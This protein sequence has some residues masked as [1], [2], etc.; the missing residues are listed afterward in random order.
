MAISVGNGRGGAKSEINVTP[1]VDVVLVLLII[2]MVVTPQLQPGKD[3][4]LPQASGAREGAPPPPALVVSITQAGEVFVDAAS[5]PA[6]A[7]LPQQLTQALREQPGRRLVLRGDRSLTYGEVRRVMQESRAAGAR[8][9]A[10]AV[11]PGKAE[12]A[13]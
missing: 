9:V 4:K 12:G 8:G 13:R 7:A 6:G 10:L 11:E 3:V 2:F 5:R 1:L